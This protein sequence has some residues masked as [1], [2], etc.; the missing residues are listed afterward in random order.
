MTITNK[1]GI[2]FDENRSLIQFVVDLLCYSKFQSGF[3]HA[4][5][6]IIALDHFQR[7]VYLSTTFQHI[8]KQRFRNEA[9]EKSG[10]G[11]YGGAG[12]CYRL[13]DRLNR[14]ESR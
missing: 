1:A 3:G 8:S 6:W 9:L 4:I 12:G 10:R 7:N 5:I 13:V 14:K 2:Y 11:N